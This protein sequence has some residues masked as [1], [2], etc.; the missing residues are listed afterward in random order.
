MSD[1]HKIENT[2]ISSDT[3]SPYQDPENVDDIVEKVKNCETHDEVVTLINETFPGWI[4]GWPMRYSL[5]Y[6]HFQN[7]W[8]FVCKKSG[9]KTLSVIIVDHIVFNNPKFSLVKLFCELLT[10]FG[11]SVR[12]KEE[13]IGCK[14]CG[15][16]IPTQS[17]YNQLRE[18]KI[19]VPSCWMVKCQKC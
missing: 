4:L 3:K 16:A 5:D 12:R 18:R 15:D 7:N 11:H 19:T 14:I 2:P 1:L 17:V 8:E 13:F 10:V 9:T 6:P